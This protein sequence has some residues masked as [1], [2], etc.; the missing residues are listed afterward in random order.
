M[1]VIEAETSGNKSNVHDHLNKGLKRET[2]SQLWTSQ[3]GTKRSPIF[4]ELN[5]Y[6]LNASSLFSLLPGPAPL[7]H[8]EI[9]LKCEK[10]H[11]N[12]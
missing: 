5:D 3:M 11:I 1:S 8:R 9:S 2:R 4:S 7:F 10:T 6:C 12:L